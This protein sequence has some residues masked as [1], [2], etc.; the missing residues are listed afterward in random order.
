MGEW[1]VTCRTD[2]TVAKAV[3]MQYSDF[4]GPEPRATVRALF[5]AF[6]VLVTAA[7][8]FCNFLYPVGTFVTSQ[9]RQRNGS[10]SRF[11]LYSN[12]SLIRFD[13]VAG[14]LKRLRTT[15]LIYALVVV[16]AASLILLRNVERLPNN[17]SNRCHT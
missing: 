10:W 14:V 16:S 6:G 4:D 13:R 5:T 11:K 3:T 12:I 7:L 17:F 8:V 1:S 9:R 2:E 15:V